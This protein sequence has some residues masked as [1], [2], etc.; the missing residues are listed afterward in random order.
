MQQVLT[1][2]AYLACPLMM[3]FCMGGM[4]KGKKGKHEQSE[5]SVTSQQE[6][7]ALQIKMGELIEQNHLL[8]KEVESLKQGPSNVVELNTDGG[9]KTRRLS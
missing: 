8:K 9:T 6:I 4:L 1:V 3:I 5:Q 7:Q 2:L